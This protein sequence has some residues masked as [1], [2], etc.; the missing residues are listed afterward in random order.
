MAEVCEIPLYNEDTEEIDRILDSYR[1]VAIIGLSNNKEKPSYMVGDYLKRHGF[2]IYPVN[3][4]Y[5]TILDERCYPD[6]LSISDQIDI[7]DIFRKPAAI[8]QIVEDAIGCGA[9]VIW[10]QSGIVNNQAAQR[11]KEAGLRVIMS[12]CMMMEHKRFMAQSQRD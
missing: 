1:N 7:V 4:R 12:R 10:M 6:L 5:E 9:R 8:P 3:P 2:R 11:A